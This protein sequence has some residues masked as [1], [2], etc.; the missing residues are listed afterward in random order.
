[1]KNLKNLEGAKMISKM[2]QK[3]IKGGYEACGQYLGECHEGYCCVNYYCLPVGM[4]LC[5]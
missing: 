5:S 4:G 3:A 2:E 1:M